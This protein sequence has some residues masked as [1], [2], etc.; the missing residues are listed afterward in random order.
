MCVC[1]CLH[2]I[3][4]R[5]RKNITT[6]FC[7]SPSRFSFYWQEFKILIGKQTSSINFKNNKITLR[8]SYFEKSSI[9]TEQTP[10]LAKSSIQLIFTL[11]FI[12]T[13]HMTII[14]N[15]VPFIPNDKVNKVDFRNSR[16]IPDHHY[17]ACQIVK[18]V[19][20]GRE[21]DHRVDPRWKL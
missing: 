10:S 8:K 5:D 16:T 12:N 9:N 21:I 13:S 3:K 7:F 20:A 18:F 6:F 4:K 17:T 19:E 1:L 14:T 2:Q 11:L 15:T